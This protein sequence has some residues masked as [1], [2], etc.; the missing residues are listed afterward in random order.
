M[1]S[2]VPILC[3]ALRPTSPAT[4]RRNRLAED[5]FTQVWSVV[6][7]FEGDMSKDGRRSVNGWKNAGLPWSYKLEKAR[8]YFP[9]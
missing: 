4:A 5:G 9:R 6:D 8:M 3:C 2:P 1:P 7:G